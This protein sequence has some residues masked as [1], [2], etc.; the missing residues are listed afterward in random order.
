MKKP[1][2]VPHDRLVRI[3]SHRSRAFHHGCKCG[4]EY[5]LDKPGSEPVFLTWGHHLPVNDPVDGALIQSIIHMSPSRRVA[6]L[7]IGDGRSFHPNYVSFSRE[8][9]AQ[10]AGDRQTGVLH[11]VRQP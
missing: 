2:G 8:G 3:R 5:N 1:I 9:R 10:S 11:H 4:G 6:Q 7:N